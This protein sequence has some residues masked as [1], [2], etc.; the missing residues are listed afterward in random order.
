MSIP[1][2]KLYHYLENIVKEIADNI[3]IYRFYPHGSKKIE[4]LEE[5]EGPISWQFQTLKIPLYCNDQEPLNYSLYQNAIQSDK[6]FNNLVQSLSLHKD[7]NLNVKPTIYDKVL[8][9]HSEKRSSNLTRYQDNQ[10][11]T[12]YYWAHAI[13]SLDWYRYAEHITQNKNTRKK[14]LVYNRAWSGTREYRLKFAELL[15]RLNLFDDC[16]MSANPIDPDIGIHYDI[17]NFFNTAWRPNTVL[18]N[19]FPL[20]DAPSHFSAEFNF[21][22]YESTD[23]EVVLETLFDD[24]RLHLTEKSLRPIACGQPF[25]LAATHGSLEYL[26]SYGFKTFG[27]IWDERYDLE[28]DPYYRLTM[29]ADTMKQIANWD[30]QKRENKMAQARA[31]AEYNKNHFFS[32]NFLNQIITELKDNLQSAV[33]EV[34]KTHDIMPFINY[35]EQLLSKK[36][37]NDFLENEVPGQ[38]PGIPTTKQ[39]NNV[40]KIVKNISQ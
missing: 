22:D 23:I 1:L 25:M 16:Q 20:N 21:K 27:H 31:I 9:L 28:E 19:F 3:V 32:K 38:H 36:E 6:D 2:D 30:P 4:N 35:W 39:V 17:H 33:V 15:I 10:F 37:I 24:D 29:I 26:R 34:H 8:L 40:L 18:E 13:I 7:Q 12:I 11:I 14:F 5:L